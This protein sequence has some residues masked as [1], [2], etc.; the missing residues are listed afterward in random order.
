MDPARIIGLA[1]QLGVAAWSLVAL[2][3]CWSETHGAWAFPMSDE[4]GEVIGI[5]LRYEN[6]I[7]RAVLGSRNG[8]F[9]PE[10]EPE[11]RL[12]VCEGPSDC[13]ACLS[14]GIWAVGRPSCSACGPMLAEFIV[15]NK[16]REAVILA[17]SDRPGIDG[18]DRLELPCRSTVLLPPAAKDVRESVALGCTREL[19]ESNLRGQVWKQP[20]GTL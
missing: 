7:K 4:R 14:L 8:L 9:I 1:G 2:G 6:G 10:M 5:R 11:R 17:D 20:S 18:A 19:L 12:F 3:A 13:A 16:V 15:R